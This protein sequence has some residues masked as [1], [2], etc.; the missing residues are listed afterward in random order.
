MHVVPVFGGPW[1]APGGPARGPATVPK[2][3]NTNQNTKNAVGV[4]QTSENENKQKTKQRKRGN[5]LWG[6]PMVFS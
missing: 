6:S 3:M 5:N 1:P 4:I 2:H